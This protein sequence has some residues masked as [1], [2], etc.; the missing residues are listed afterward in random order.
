M[1]K[2]KPLGEAG[3]L[4]AEHPTALLL[5]LKQHH[6]VAR[7]AGGRRRLRL[8]ACACCRRVWHLFADEDSRRAVE[9]A[10]RYADGRATR[11]ELEAAGQSAEA[12]VRRATGR[13]EGLTGGR[14]WET[15]RE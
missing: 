3:W 9:V 13:V 10:E 12:A 7:S 6:G 5:D 1:S 2:R 4:S 15:R 8:F 14:G 11:D